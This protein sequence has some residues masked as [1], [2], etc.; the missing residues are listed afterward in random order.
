MANC[1]RCGR[2]LKNKLSIQRGYGPGCYKK[3][4][5]DKNKDVDIKQEEITRKEVK[6]QMNILEETRRIKPNM[7][8]VSKIYFKILDRNRVYYLL[9][10]SYASVDDGYIFTDLIEE[11]EY[12]RAL[13][14]GERTEELEFDDARPNI[15]YE[16]ENIA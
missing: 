6:G 1:L 15:K 14:K 2:P 5:I 4:N 12:L 10:R 8:L 13:K 16:I 11:E 7:P 9:E 3:L